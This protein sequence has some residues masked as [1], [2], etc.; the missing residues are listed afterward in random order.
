[1]T[2]TIEPAATTL[3]EANSTVREWEGRVAAAR[4]ALGDYQRDAGAAALSGDAGAVSSR[5]GELQNNLVVAE[6][7]LGEAKR[8]VGDAARAE[9]VERVRAYRQQAAELHATAEAA[10][11][12][13]NEWGPKV[14][15]ARNVMETAARQEMQIEHLIERLEGA[16]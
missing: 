4:A 8:R 11:T 16:L 7:A 6:A 3:A 14:E 2:A 10:A 15:Q 1:M 9:R 12:F 5:L 13:V